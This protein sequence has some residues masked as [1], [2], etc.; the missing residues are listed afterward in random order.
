MTAARS[1]RPQDPKPPSHAAQTPIPPE[2]TSRVVEIRMA[3]KATTELEQATEQYE[4]GP[5]PGEDHS[6]KC[7]MLAHAN[8]AT[9]RLQAGQLDA[10]ITAVEP[11]LTLASGNRTATLTGRLAAVRIE[12]HQPRYQGSPQARTLDERIEEFCRDTVVSELHSL[13]GGLG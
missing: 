6:H 3:A 5:G 13:P 4:A 1:S 7:R 11:V 8:L 9:A 2:L 10:A 12:L